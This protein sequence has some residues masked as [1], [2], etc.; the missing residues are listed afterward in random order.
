MLNTHF[1]DG[2]V[3]EIYQNV[4][5]LD[6][7]EIELMDLSTTLQEIFIFVRDFKMSDG[8][9]NN[10]LEQLKKDAYRTLV[11][12]KQ[13]TKNNIDGN[14][15]S[16]DDLLPRV[17]RILPREDPDSIIYFIEQLADVI[18]RGPCNNGRINRLLQVYKCLVE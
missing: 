7:S 3:K 8:S 11:L 5:Q 17:W 1:Y 18:T 9:T 16:V 12:F 13:D 2:K 10:N 6:K 14:G 15:L 4:I